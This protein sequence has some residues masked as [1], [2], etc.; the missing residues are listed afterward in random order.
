MVFRGGVSTGH[1]DLPD[2]AGAT[3]R[4]TCD[5][6]WLLGAW[7]A[8][9][10]P[11]RFFRRYEK[12]PRLQGFVKGITAAAAGAIAGAAIVIARQTVSGAL[13]VLIGIVAL[14]LLL[15]RRVKIPEPALVAVAALV[16]LALHDG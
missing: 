10:S 15:Q 13:S 5:V 2:D 9:R 12:H 7:L 14:G 4:A 3:R 11:G 6:A 1:G 16:G 8:G